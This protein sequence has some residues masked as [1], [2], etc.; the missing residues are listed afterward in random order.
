MKKLILI[1]LI[2][3]AAL[4][5]SSQAYMEMGAGTDF[6]H[7]VAVINAG[8]QTHN[9]IVIE[10]ILSPSLTRNLAHNYFGAIAGYNLTRLLHKSIIP[11]IGYYYDKVSNDDKSMN[12]NH[13]GYS[14]KYIQHLPRAIGYLFGN[15]LYINK[16]VQLT[17]GVGVD[18]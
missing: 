7:P 12:G 6:N 3:I 11:G 17:A 18:L 13:V 9:N 1:S 8:V 15:V 5:A 16:Q 10:G 14:I 2:T 4:N